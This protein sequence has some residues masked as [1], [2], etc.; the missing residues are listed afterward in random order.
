MPTDA[1]LVLDPFDSG[2][3]ARYVELCREARVD[4]PPLGWVREQMSRWNQMLS[5]N[6]AERPAPQASALVVA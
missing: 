3:Y 5:I 4:P 1:D 2:L 6:A